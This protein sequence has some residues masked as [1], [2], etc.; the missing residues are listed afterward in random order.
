MLIR[1]ALNVEVG[2]NDGLS[3]PFLLFLIALAA[4]K[5]EGGAASFMQFIVEQ[6]GYGVLAD[7]GIGLVVWGVL[8]SR[9]PQGVSGRIALMGSARGLESHACPRNRLKNFI[10]FE[11]RKVLK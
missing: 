6:P 1:Q 3:V 11:P 4:A 9:P 10:A 7:G 2:L 8:E 5:T